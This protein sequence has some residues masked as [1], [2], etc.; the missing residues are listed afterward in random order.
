MA[1]ARLPLTMSNA[2]FFFYGMR[3]L[4]SQKQTHAKYINLITS[5]PEINKLCDQSI[6]F[7]SNLYSPNDPRA[8]DL[9]FVVKMRKLG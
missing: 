4:H 7:H 5:R 3:I 8:Y 9:I 2:A 1:I 6:T